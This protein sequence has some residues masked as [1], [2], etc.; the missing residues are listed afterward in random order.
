MQPLPDGAKQREEEEAACAGAALKLAREFLAKR[1][2]KEEGRQ[3]KKTFAQGQG[4]AQNRALEQLDRGGMAFKLERGSGE[5]QQAAAN[6]PSFSAEAAA[7][8]AAAAGTAKQA[9]SEMFRKNK[10]RC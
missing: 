6:R 3:E 5:A 10:G 4:F 8:P 2:K 1:E 9:Y 7:A